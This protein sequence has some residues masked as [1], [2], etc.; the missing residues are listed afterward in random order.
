MSVRR[1]L[2]GLILLAGSVSAQMVSAGATARPARPLPPGMKAPVIDFRD[3]AVEAGLTAV[4]VSGRE[5][6]KNYII[7]DTGN[8]VALFDYDNDGLLDILFVNADFLEPVAPKPKLH[9]Y[10]NLGGLRFEEVTDKAGLGHTGWGQG[11][12]TADFDEDGHLDFLVT[13]WGQ[14]LL[15]RNR[16]DGTFQDEARQRGLAW[17]KPRWSTGCAFLDYDRD[18]DLDLFVANYLEFDQ[19]RTPKPGDPE[20]C[21]WRGIGVTC[22]PRGLPGENM[23][24]FR[25]DG[26]GHYT[27][28]SAQ[29]GIAGP[30]DY[31]GLTVLTGDYD[32]DGWVDV[33]VASDSTPSLLFNNK[34]DGT[35]EEVGVY[36]GAAYNEDGR[37]QA[38]MGASAADFDG[39]GFLD[40]LKTNFSNDIPT[41]YRNNGDGSFTDVAVTAGLAV[42]THFVRWGAAFLDIDNDGWKD[43]FNAAGHVYPEVDKLPGSETFRQQRLIYW[44]R[45]DGQFH[46]MSGRS[47][48]GILAKFTSRGVAVG[49]LDNDGSVEIVVV[50]M[51]QRPSLLRNFGDR[52]SALLVQALTASGRDAIGAR[53]MV[54]AASRSQRDEVRS[55]G[56]YISQG[57]M[58]VH[59]GLGSSKTASVSIRWPD[60][61]TDTFEDVAADQWIVLR[62]GKGIVRSV[63]LKAAEEP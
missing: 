31:Y 63:K 15:Y 58:R 36:S 11:V 30:K 51:H 50:N 12:C 37:E 46:D 44:N 7:E 2:C 60:G 25:N 23:T 59:F 32:N 39:N 34:R 42:H 19:A 29:A 41:L 22:G 9:L 16:G 8:G 26:R 52:G 57:D 45:G 62:Q 14:N 27:D 20:Q 6:R 33:Y 17:P 38:G 53:I 5:G 4:N 47:G 56:Y 40:I 24:L 43:V 1:E 49:D 55:G 3:L 10:R 54:T 48:A 61:K 35:F 21:T 18:G 13:Q 28:V